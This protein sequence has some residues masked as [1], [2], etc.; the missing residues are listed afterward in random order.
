MTARG[1]S[2]TARSVSELRFVDLCAGL[3]GFHRALHEAEAQARQRSSQPFSKN[4]SFRCVLAAELDDEL[5]AVYVQN[6]PDLVA[7]YKRL[8]PPERV[9]QVPELTDLYEDDQLVR[10]HG[11]IRTLLDG[12]DKLR[13]WPGTTHDFLVPEHDLLCA[14]FP[15]QPFSKSGSQKGFE[16][17]NGTVFR[18]LAVILKHRKP[19]Y[20]LLENVGNFERHDGGNT[21]HRVREVLAELGYDIRA[22]THVGSADGGDG[23]LSPHHLGLPH[24]RERFFVVAQR[25][26]L[27]GSFPE[28]RHPFPL[29]HRNTLDS[30]AHREKAERAAESRLTEII[31]ES[32]AVATVE[33]F[34]AAAL[35]PDRVRC[36]DHWNSLLAKIQDHDERAKLHSEPEIGVPSFPIWGYEL[37][38]WNHYPSHS[39]PADLL[40]NVEALRAH[41]RKLVGHLGGEA[42]ISRESLPQGERSY[43]ASSE[44]S[45]ADLEM[46]VSSWPKYASA[47]G[48]WPQWKQRFI[49]LSR[50][51]GLLLWQRMDGKWLRAWIDE[52]LTFVPSHQK[53]EFNCMGGDAD[54]W[55]HILQFRPSG[56]RVKR[57][58]HVPALVAMTP[59][60]I[61]VVP[62][63]NRVGGG[64]GGRHILPS[65]G[66]ALQGFPRTWDLPKARGDAFAA[67]GNGVHVG[68]VAEIVLTWLF[69]K[70]GP[71]DRTG[72]LL[73]EDEREA[74]TQPVP[75]PTATSLFANLPE[76]PAVPQPAARLSRRH[77]PRVA[78]GGVL[79]AK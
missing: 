12:D 67:L 1:D 45:D 66:L 18:M 37:D 25:M 77:A 73:K 28:R 38:P 63:I 58:C 53:L 41:R 65:E 48:E 56:L 16:D 71:Y 29:I 59:T 36:I 61:P 32:E 40:G 24:H 11:D 14:G 27:A 30:Q 42:W 49:R 22:T 62:R 64:P 72:K 55:T 46:W 78:K 54:L 31:V 33:D 15:C 60:Q 69:E 75:P 35:R 26:D 57:R 2:G 52:L 7:E 13:T 3:G 9:R 74:L 70:D 76:V 43:L 6:F 50:E 4:Y 23:L 10:I 34:S 79:H 19:Q 47:R 21:W 20:V 8:H 44:P 5:R 68:L 17:L 51:W 39:N